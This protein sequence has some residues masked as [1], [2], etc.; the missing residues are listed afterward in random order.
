MI[1]ALER[2]L[3]ES[4]PGVVDCELKRTTGTCLP[5][6]AESTAST[7]AGGSTQQP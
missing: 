6:V 2:W 4:E 1:T 3:E 7:A 5:D